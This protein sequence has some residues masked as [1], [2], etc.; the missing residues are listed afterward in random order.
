MLNIHG[1]L[2][3]VWGH[4]TKNVILEYYN[5]VILIFVREN[6]NRVDCIFLNDL[7]LKVSHN[8]PQIHELVMEL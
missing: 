3:L 2:C 8:V 6:M 1:S 4:S 5:F 7:A